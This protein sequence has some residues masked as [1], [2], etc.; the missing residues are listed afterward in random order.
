MQP[1]DSL[2]GTQ[3]RTNWPAATDNTSFKDAFLVPYDQAQ[4]NGEVHVSKEP[5]HG[6]RTGGW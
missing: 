3:R 4:T 5:M 6:L 2:R 1:I